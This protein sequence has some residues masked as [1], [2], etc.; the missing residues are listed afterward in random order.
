MRAQQLSWKLRI[1]MLISGIALVAVLWLP[2]WRIELNAPQYPEGLT[3]LIYANKIGG[4]VDIVNGLNHYIGM[5]TL[6]TEDFAEFRILP[7]IVG[8]FAVFAIATGIAGRKK[9]LYS[10]TIAL[11][12]FGIVALADFWKWEYDYGHHLNPDAAIVVPGMAY[13]PPLIGFKQLLNFGAYSIPDI[14]GWIFAG[15]GMLALIC[16]IFSLRMDRLKIHSLSIL[17]LLTIV[18]SVSCNN[19]AA[20]IQAGTDHCDFCRMTITDLK[21][22]AALVTVKG[23]TYKFDDLHCLSSFLAGG[24]VT[25]K[26]VR[27]V[28][29]AN[30]NKPEQLIKTGEAVFYQSDK[31]RGPMGGNIIA[32]PSGDAAALQQLQASFSGNIIQWHALVVQ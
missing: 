15:V 14:G 11:V 20:P 27:D 21:Y 25:Q 24:Q 8:L 4:N 22:S 12:I 9:W 19:S 26:S 7:W 1:P 16:S 17:L 29:A 23:R 13:Q 10:F 31:I 28:Y 32:V 5:K 2:F 30:Y 3:L 6:H 18:S